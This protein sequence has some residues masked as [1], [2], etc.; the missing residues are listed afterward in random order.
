MEVLYSGA[1]GAVC[2]YGWNRQDADVVCRQLG[3]GGALA[4]PGNSLFG[5]GSG[6]KWLSNVRCAGNE[7]SLAACEHSGWGSADCWT[8]DVASAICS[9]PGDKH[10]KRVQI[11]VNKIR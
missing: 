2:G 9:K 1:W 11:P 4:A 7:S 6:V 5:E 10:A 3:H 8:S